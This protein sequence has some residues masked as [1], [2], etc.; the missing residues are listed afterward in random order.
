MIEN[1]Q[2]IVIRRS[3]LKKA[4][5]ELHSHPRNADFLS[6]SYFEERLFWV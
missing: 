2:T 6:R 3:M 4:L 1:S 5:I